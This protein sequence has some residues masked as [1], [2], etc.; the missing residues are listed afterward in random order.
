MG[1]SDQILVLSLI[2]SNDNTVFALCSTKVEGIEYCNIQYGS[3]SSYNNLSLPITGHTNT[4]FQIPFQETTPCT[5]YFQAYI[6]IN[7]TLKIIVR[8]R[9]ELFRFSPN[10]NENTADS[11][12]ALITT[13][14]HATTVTLELYQV[15]LIGAVG[16]IL[17]LVVCICIGNKV[18][19][20]YKSKQVQ[21]QVHDI[22]C[23]CTIV[24]KRSKN[25]VTFDENIR[26]LRKAEPS[27]YDDVQFPST[28]REANKDE[29]S[30]AAVY[31]EIPMFT[32]N[33][34]IPI[35]C[36]RDISLTLNSAYRTTTRNTE[37]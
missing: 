3:D 24:E 13:S 19:Q 29:D 21:V 11:T 28:G 20:V 35:P 27:S 34:S 8:S 12:T 5:H 14:T 32:T 1:S 36:K 31:D 2:E 30:D 9:K 37:C 25:L 4:L 17:L 10:C 6:V 18:L 26:T 16:A 15:G 33:H 22:Q 7:S 23:S